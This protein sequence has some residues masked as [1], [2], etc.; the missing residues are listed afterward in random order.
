M[1]VSTRLMGALIDH[2]DDNGLVL[3][4][5]LAPI[6]VVIIPIYSGSD[7][8]EIISLVAKKIKEELSAIGISVKYDDR[9]NFKP[10]FKF[11]DYD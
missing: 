7:Q 3:P 2:S 6:Q 1:G 5:N 9:D 4:P 8:L 11:N 10:G